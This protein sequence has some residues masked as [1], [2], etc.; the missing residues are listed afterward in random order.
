MGLLETESWIEEGNQGFAFR[1]LDVD[2]EH[3][4]LEK[5]THGETTH[6][7]KPRKG[8]NT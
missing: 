5:E 7:G 4:N 6:Q 3:K 1:I 2:K 8:S